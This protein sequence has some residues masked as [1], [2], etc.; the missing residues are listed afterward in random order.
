LS[1]EGFSI[2]ASSRRRQ[3][4]MPPSAEKPTEQDINCQEEN[5]TKDAVKEGE[6][7]CELGQGVP[8]RQTA[9]GEGSTSPLSQAWG[10]RSAN[11]GTP[12]A[13]GPSQHQ[14]PTE[15]AQPL[16]VTTPKNRTRTPTKLP[17]SDAST[18]NG[19]GAPPP[20]KTGVLG[21]H[22]RASKVRG[23]G[24]GPQRHLEEGTAPAAPTTS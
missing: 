14:T 3:R 13:H 5:V 21:F 11:S 17:Q 6:G 20:P 15:I 9:I 2:V 4:T 8:P 23:G 24:G 16:L 12:G 1:G 7:E 19:A 10:R 18:G 22:P